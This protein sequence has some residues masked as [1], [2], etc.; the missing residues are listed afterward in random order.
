MTTADKLGIVAGGGELPKRV[1][2]ACRD[3]GRPF[4][5]LGLEGQVD[6]DW[7]ESLSDKAVVRPGALKRSMELMRAAGAREVVLAGKVR[8]PSITE[9][10][11]DALAMKLL[12][13]A[14]RKAFGDDGLLSFLIN[15][16]DGEGFRILSV[17]QVL[18]GQ[19]M[20]PGPMGA[21]SPDDEAFADIRRGVVVLDALSPVDVGQ[22]VVVQSGLVLGVE[23]IEGT[24]ALLSRAGTLRREG[25][26]GVLVKL[27]KSGQSDRVDVPAVGP[28][29]VRNA[30]AA[31]LQ[32]I[33]IDAGGMVL[34]DREEMTRLADEAGLFIMAIDRDDFL[35]PGVR[36]GGGEKK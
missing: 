35:V 19:K 13:Q 26:G 6:I 20:V 15:Y 30:H 18:P 17:D 14:G 21:H 23:A 2:E 32:G 33:A 25:P 31:G 12:L 34:I 10:R 36:D 29:T 11:P 8:R 24:D 16:L 1:V 5:V 7:L 4:Y 22:A 27:R 28:D 9:L 3:T